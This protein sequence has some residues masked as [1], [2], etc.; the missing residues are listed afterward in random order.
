MR[1]REE[2]N[3]SAIATSTRLPTGVHVQG[4]LTTNM[5]LLYV[6][7]LCDKGPEIYTPFQLVI[8][9]SKSEECFFQS[10]VH[11]DLQLWE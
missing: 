3:F 11:L 8:Q 9:K 1:K 6:A 4:F 5:Q 10:I 2:D 7:L